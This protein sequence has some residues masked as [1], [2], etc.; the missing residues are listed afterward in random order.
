[1]TKVDSY[2][3]GKFALAY[4]KL[5]RNKMAG[6]RRI[7]RFQQGRAFPNKQL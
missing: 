6:E 3:I 2:G 1:M 5:Q 4:Y 7:K